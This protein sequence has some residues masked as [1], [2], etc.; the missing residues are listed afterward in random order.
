MGNKEP[1]TLAKRGSA[2][3]F[4]RPELVVGIHVCLVKM[5]INSSEQTPAKM[6]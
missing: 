3:E 4:V 5:T 1:G 2:S 6:G